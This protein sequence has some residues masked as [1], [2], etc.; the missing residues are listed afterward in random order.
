MSH[1]ADF[2]IGT[3]ESDLRQ[4]FDEIE[5]EEKKPK[6]TDEQLIENAMKKLNDESKEEIIKN[7]CSLIKILFALINAKEILEQEKLEYDRLMK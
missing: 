4:A 2:G 1:P 5:A 3:W 7:Y 6:L